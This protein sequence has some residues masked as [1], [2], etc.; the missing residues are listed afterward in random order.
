VNFLSRLFRKPFDV[1]GGAMCDKEFPWVTQKQQPQKRDRPQRKKTVTHFTFG[2]RSLA[3][4]ARRYSN[5]IIAPDT[6]NPKNFLEPQ[7]LLYAF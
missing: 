6:Q 4:D 7:N 2:Y 1:F 5:D 3:P